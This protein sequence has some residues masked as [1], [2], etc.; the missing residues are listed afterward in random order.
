M[1]HYP[2]TVL[3][4]FTSITSYDSRI[5]VLAIVKPFKRANRAECLNE[6]RHINQPFL[7]FFLS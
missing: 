5:E 7:L 1:L 4:T 3:R 2:D 6:T